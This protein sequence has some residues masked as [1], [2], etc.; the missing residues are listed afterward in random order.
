M[1]A[2]LIK[3]LMALTPYRVS[4]HRE[5]RFDVTHSCLWHLRQLGYQPRFI[6]DGGAFLGTFADAAQRAFPAAEIHVVEPQPGARAPLEAMA[7]QRGWTFHACALDDQVGNLRL[8]CLAVPNTGAHVT[9]A[10]EEA[11][12]V[13]ASTVDTLFGSRLRADSHALLKLDLQ[14]HELRALRGA[15]ASLPSIEL[16]LVEVSFFRQYLE[17]SIPELVNFLDQQG[18]DLFDVVGLSGRTRDGRLR[19]GDFVFVRRGTVLL[20]DT[21]WA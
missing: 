12:D 15:M 9:Y 14:G 7:R 3:K 10:E 6:I 13:P 18:F 11:A 4:R 5:N 21:A 2:G 1:I 17:P 8:A 19:Q 20:A 16:V